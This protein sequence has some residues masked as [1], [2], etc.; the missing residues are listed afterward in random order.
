[1]GH[2]GGCVVLLVRSVARAIAP[3]ALTIRFL[4]VLVINHIVIYFLAPIL[5]DAHLSLLDHLRLD[6]LLALDAT[7]DEHDYDED[8]HSDAS[9]SNIQPE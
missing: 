4:Q 3:L 2:V 6:L 5:H 1:M 7:V 9:T 8:D